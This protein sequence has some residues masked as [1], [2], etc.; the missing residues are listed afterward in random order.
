VA[1]TGAAW[2]AA[3]SGGYWKYRRAL[4]DPAAAQR[5]LLMEYVRLNADTH[6]GHR[7]GF[8]TIRSVA[9]Y[10]ARVPLASYG[11]GPD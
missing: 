7:H 9:D 2:V 8:S 5:A 1:A 3:N 6:F 10:Q 4:A 11:D